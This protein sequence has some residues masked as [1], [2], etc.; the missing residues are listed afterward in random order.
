MA[1][2][3]ALTS[4]TP[5]TLAKAGEVTGNFSSI[6]NT[7]NTYGMFT[8][9]AATVT[10]GHLYQATQTFTPGS[11]YAVDITTGGA[12]IQA[13]GLLVTAGN[14]ALTAGNLTFGAASA[15]VIPGATSLLFR[16]TADAN[17]NLSITDA[18]AVTVRAGLTVSGSG[19]AVTGNS[20]IAGTLGSITT[21]TANV[22]A[23]GASSSKLLIGSSDLLIRDSGDS[24]TI[25]TINANNV[26]LASGKRFSCGGGSTGSI[27]TAS[28][29]VLIASGAGAGMVEIGIALAT[30]A[31][32]GFLAIGSCS[33]TPTGAPTTTGSNMIPVLYDR[34]NN[35]ICFYNGSWR[36]VAVT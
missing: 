2:I 28:N 20:T 9:V 4:F 29:N 31:T 27:D 23:G 24:A 19:I 8:D 10:V 5:G 30:N 3:P 1:L 17:T 34:L 6:R 35:R 12:R 16:D 32:T 36:S 33:G 26:Q 13:G 11:G 7:L 22:F 14:V 18:G 15:K 21:I 25:V